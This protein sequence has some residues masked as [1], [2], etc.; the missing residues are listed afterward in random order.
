MADFSHE[1]SPTGGLSRPMVEIAP[2]S[3]IFPVDDRFV[4]RANPAPIEL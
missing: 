1:T 3:S 2:S 4:Q